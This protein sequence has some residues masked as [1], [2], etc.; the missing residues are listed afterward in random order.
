MITKQLV[1]SGFYGDG[2]V[3][4]PASLVHRDEGANVFR[5]MDAALLRVHDILLVLLSRRDCSPRQVNHH[6]YSLSAADQ[7][8]GIRIRAESFVFSIDLPQRLGWDFAGRKPLH[9]AV[10]SNE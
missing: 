4:L 10:G 6:I 8:H 5:R 2:S 1:G 9:H 7:R 3:L